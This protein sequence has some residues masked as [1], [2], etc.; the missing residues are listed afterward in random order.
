MLAQTARLCICNLKIVSYFQ[1]LT[2]YAPEISDMNYEL[3]E[4]EKHKKCQK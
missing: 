1:N 4:E 2:P 3:Q